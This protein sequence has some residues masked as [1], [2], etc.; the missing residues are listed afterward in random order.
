[1]YVE[2]HKQHKQDYVCRN[3]YYIPFS[4]DHQYTK[5]LLL[6]KLSAVEYIP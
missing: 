4:G 6:A 5:Y 3:N 2:K 1:M